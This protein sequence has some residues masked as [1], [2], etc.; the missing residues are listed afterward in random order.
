MPN[1]KFYLN[2]INKGIRKEY[3]AIKGGTQTLNITGSITTLTPHEK[4]TYAIITLESD[5]INVACRYW[6]GGDIPTSSSGMPINHLGSR[7]IEGREN[8]K[9]FKITQ[10]I[11]GA[12]TLT[13]EYYE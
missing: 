11:A 2:N 9:N 3:Q 8:L 1:E 13:V 10:A 5:A 7:D 12:H 6:S 4:A